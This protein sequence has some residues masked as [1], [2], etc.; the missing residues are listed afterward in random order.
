MQHAYISASTL[1]LP[2]PL[3]LAV[4]DPRGAAQEAWEIVRCIQQWPADQVAR[5]MR[6]RA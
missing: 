4:P 2:L 6:G 1:L 3:R 5:V